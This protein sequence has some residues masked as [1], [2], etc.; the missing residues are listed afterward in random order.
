MTVSSGRLVGGKRQ[1]WNTGDHY[2]ILFWNK[3]TSWY[4]QEG[5]HDTQKG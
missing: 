4:G 5:F 3:F 2:L 1:T